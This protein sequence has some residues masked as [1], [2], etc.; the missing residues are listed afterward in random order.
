MLDVREASLQVGIVGAGLMGCGIAQI[1]V[2]AGVQV[3]LY[4]TDVQIASK[5]SERIFAMLQKLLSKQKITAAQLQSAHSKLKT[6]AQ[7]EELADCDLLIEAI[8]EDLSCKQA[9]FVKLEQLVNK[10]CIL[11]TNTSSLSVSAIAAQCQYPQ[12]VAGYHFFSPVP[13]MK[14]VEVIAAPL[15]EQWVIQALLELARRVG[16]SPVIAKDTPGFIVNHAGRGLGTEALRILSEN[17][18]TEVDIDRILR[19]AGRFRMGAFELLDLVGLDVSHPVMESIYKQYYFEPRFRPSPIT[20]QRLVAGLLGRKTGQGFF[21]YDASGKVQLP[22]ETQVK[23]DDV[24]PIWLSKKNPEAAESVSAWLQKMDVTIEQGEQPSPQAICLLLPLGQDCATLAWQEK[25]DPA[26]CIALDCL[27]LTGRRTLMRNLLTEDKVVQKALGLFSS[28][29][30]PVTLINDSAGLVLQRVLA[31]I[32]NI[33]CD[34]AQQAIAKPED[35]D[36]AVTLGLGYPRGPFAWGDHIGGK[37]ILQ[38][39]HNLQAFYGDPRYRPSPWLTRRAS[40]GLSL[41]TPEPP[42]FNIGE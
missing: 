24:P 33:A 8:V 10:N 12:R 38:I 11:A 23:T 18:A 17:V 4:D 26:R 32:I 28:D 36:L 39:L 9:L 30:T 19:D 2:Q 15:T 16:H 3:Y 35:I 41:L 29:G 22:K 37:R 14:L 40:L 34:M 7:L 25:L 13:L 27:A 20:H 21:T 42:S 5:G 6:A 1:L 31:L